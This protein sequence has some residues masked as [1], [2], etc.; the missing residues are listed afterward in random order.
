VPGPADDPDQ[1]EQCFLTIQHRRISLPY[2][3]SL[4]EIG[5]TR[6][7]PSL[8]GDY[9]LAIS[10]TSLWTSARTL[11]DN[12]TIRTEEHRSA[13]LSRKSRS[14]LQIG[15]SI[16]RVGKPLFLMSLR[17]H[18][19]LSAAPGRKESATLA[20]EGSGSLAV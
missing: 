4:S 20:T 17:S 11:V 15:M 3:H 1:E 5:K 10:Q 9:G 18:G 13:C 16:E 19:S 6:A 8:I 14:D 7:S 12:C 2:S